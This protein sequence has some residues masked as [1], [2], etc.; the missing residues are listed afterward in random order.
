MSPAQ[1]NCKTTDSFV[2]VKNALWMLIKYFS[3]QKSPQIP[4]DPHSQFDS[5]P[6]LEIWYSPKI[7]R[8]T[9]AGLFQCNVSWPQAA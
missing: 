2:D 1:K 7:D 6:N 4:R 9:N 5:Y 3:C 8:I